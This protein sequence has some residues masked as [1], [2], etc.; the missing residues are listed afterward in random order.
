MAKWSVRDQQGQIDLISHQLFGKRGSKLVFDFP[1][2]PHTAH[3][4]K[5]EPGKTFDYA[6]RRKLCQRGPRKD[7]LWIFFGDPANARMMVYHDGT[8]ARIGRYLAV[9]QVFPRSERLL[10]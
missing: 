2:L 1:M 9:A 4:R 3:E 10:I 7:D 6:A 8:G 5:V